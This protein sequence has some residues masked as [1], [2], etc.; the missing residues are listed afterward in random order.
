MSDIRY[1]LANRGGLVYGIESEQYQK[2]ASVETSP[3]ITYEDIDPPNPNEHTAMAHGGTGRSVF[4]NSPDEKDYEF[5]VPVIVHDE[6]AP[7]ELALGSRTET[8][9]TDYTEVLFEER[10]RLPTATFSYFHEDLDF[11]ASYIGS[12]ASLDV[13]WDEEDPLEATFSVTSAA[14]EASFD[15]DAPAADDPARDVSPYRA[16]MA[17]DVTLSEPDGGG[18]VAELATVTG[19]SLS[20]D[21]GLEPQHHGGEAGREAYAVAET[22]AADGRYDWTLTMNVTDTDL[23]QRAY[24]NAEP[25]DVEIPFVRGSSD[26]TWTDAVIVRGERCVITD[27]PIGAPSEGVIASDVQLLPESTEIE[28]RVPN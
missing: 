20:W 8:D 25:V 24:E 16:H 26:D 11:V 14:L 12:K 9:Q 5:D 10:S 27:A 7:F 17:G 4:V 15:A 19:G 18:V 22:T 6:N 21:N 2:S 1:A 23:F 28:V 3:G 13:E